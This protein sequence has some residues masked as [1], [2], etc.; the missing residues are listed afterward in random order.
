MLIAQLVTFLLGTEC[1]EE[2]AMLKD[3]LKAYAGYDVK[4]FCYQKLEVFIK[5][6]KIAFKNHKSKTSHS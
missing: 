4:M 2:D 5:E 6:K 1:R 3:M